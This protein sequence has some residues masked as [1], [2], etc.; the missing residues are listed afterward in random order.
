MQT[1]GN[2]HTC[3]ITWKACSA[4]A[5][6][7]KVKRLSSC[8]G[9]Q[10]NAGQRLREE[11]GQTLRSVYL[12]A[13]RHPRQGRSF[14]ADRCA[15]AAERPVARR[16]AR[17]HV[18]RHPERL[19]AVRLRDAAIT[20]QQLDDLARGIR[21]QPQTLSFDSVF[22]PNTP[23][24]DLKTVDFAPGAALTGAQHRARRWDS[25][26][27]ERANLEDTLLV[28]DD[29]CEPLTSMQMERLFT[30]SRRP[31]D[32]ATRQSRQR[33]YFSRGNT[34]P[35]AAP[36]LHRLRRRSGWCARPRSTPRRD[37]NP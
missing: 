28:T 1:R 30:P 25:K 23:W 21:P 13:K 5:K 35:T 10:A 27:A 19:D 24:V 18:R 2:P 20:Q 17:E 3:L 36:W 34:W 9:A 12:L 4:L 32:A 7:Q 37:R 22:A 31:L 14:G 29:G 26:P 33:K 8:A 16:L 15:R 11:A 6:M